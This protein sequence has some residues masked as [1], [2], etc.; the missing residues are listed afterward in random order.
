MNTYELWLDIGVAALG[1]IAGIVGVWMAWRL[2]RPDD[3]ADI[4]LASL[5]QSKP[6]NVNKAAVTVKQT[7]PVATP[8]TVAKA[9]AKKKPAKSPQ[10]KPGPSPKT[11]VFQSNFKVPS[12]EASRKQPALKVLRIQHF[13]PEEI[14]IVLQNTGGTLIFL[15][16]ITA[17]FNEVEIAYSPPIFRDE[18]RYVQGTSMHIGIKGKNLEDRT[19]HFSIRFIDLE[20]NQFKQEVAGMGLEKP[21]VEKPVKVLGPVSEH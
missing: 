7:A 21:I 11:E 15:E 9:P 8:P 16:L 14:R 20:G 13:S 19:Y 1:A 5:A 6:V 18:E 4:S 3:N 2:M 17:E 12:R 10:A